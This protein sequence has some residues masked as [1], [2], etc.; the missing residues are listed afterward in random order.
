MAEI[1]SFFKDPDEKL[2]Y[3]RDWTARLAGDTIATS[4][5]TRVE[6]DP[7]G[8]VIDS[9]THTDS[10]ATVWLTGGTLGTDVHVTNHVTTA[11]GREFD[12]TLRFQIRAR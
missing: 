9:D 3:V 10:T 4:D 5:W 12:K 1:S 11:G 2:D 8:L 6:D 7:G